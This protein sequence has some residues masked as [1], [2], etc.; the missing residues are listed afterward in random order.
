MVKKLS[1]AF[2]AVAL[3]FCLQPAFGAEPDD[4]PDFRPGFHHGRH[5]GDFGPKGGF[6][7]M[8]GKMMGMFGPRMMDEL[9]LTDAQKT[10]LIDVATKNFKEGLTLRMEMGDARRKLRDLRDSDNPDSAAI[11]AAN[12]AMGA[13]K[14]RMEVLGQNARQ[15]FRAILTPEQQAKLDER[16]ADFEE[17]RESRR[18]DRGDRGPADGPRHRGPGPKGKMKGGPRPHRMDWCD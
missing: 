12:E 2:A 3:A 13:F 14:G 18:G 10:Q 4:E 1:L 7:P 16:K 9:E 5:M 6:G 11:I 8:G 15:E 17:W